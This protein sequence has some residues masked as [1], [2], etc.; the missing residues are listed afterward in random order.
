MNCSEYSLVLKLVS[1]T[2]L[3][4]ASIEL[5]VSFD[6]ICNAASISEHNPFGLEVYVESGHTISNI[7]QYMYI[8]NGTADNTH[9]YCYLCDEPQSNWTQILC[10]SC[11]MGISTDS[12]DRINIDIPYVD[13]L[14]FT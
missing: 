9:E 3:L 6:S 10:N 14:Q 8:I 1:N 2:V 13:T 11:A 5:S 7:D 4:G 12:V